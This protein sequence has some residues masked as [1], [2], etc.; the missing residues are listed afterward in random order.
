MA[1][2]ENVGMYGMYGKDRAAAAALVSFK[3]MIIFLMV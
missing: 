3:G 1:R 2:L